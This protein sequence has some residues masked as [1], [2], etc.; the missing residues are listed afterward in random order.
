MGMRRTWKSDRP[1]QPLEHMT[2]PGPV[3]LEEYERTHSPPAQ[4]DTVL[5]ATYKANIECY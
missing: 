2:I 4:D 1:Q 3:S 5:Y